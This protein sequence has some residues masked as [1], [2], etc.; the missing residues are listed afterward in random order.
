MN[1]ADTKLL[2]RL[3]E[4]APWHMDIALSPDLTTAHGNKNHPGVAHVTST[5]TIAAL[6]KAIYPTG[7]T[8]KSFLDVACNCGGHAL[9]AREMNADPVLGFDVREQWI[10]QACFLKA[11]LFPNNDSITFK[12]CDLR[13]A[14]GFLEKLDFDIC[15][16]KGIFYH[17]PDPV[18]SLEVIANHTRDLL[19]IDTDT[20]ARE[21]DGFLKLVKESSDNPIS[22]VHELAWLPTGPRVIED[23]LGWLGFT[24]TRL[25]FWKQPEIRQR[26]RLRIIA[27]RNKNT[28]AYFDD[29]HSTALD[30]PSP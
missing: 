11:H 17:M 27:A 6:L 7:L 20:A 15:L 2:S 13:D 29:C 5:A 22:G 28:L 30:E 23:I 16:Y 18:T 10:K 26:G 8:N 1:S 19:I 12:Q 9:V 25:I 21:K 14:A 4:L 24:E 3:C